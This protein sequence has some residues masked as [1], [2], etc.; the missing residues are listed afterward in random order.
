[1]KRFLLSI[2]L[3]IVEGLTEFLPVSS[4]GHL[5]IVESALQAESARQLLEDVHDRDPA[6]RDPGVAGLFSETNPG[7]SE[8]ISKRRAW[9]SQFSDA[10]AE[11]DDGRVCGH[12]AAGV[13]VDQSDREEPRKPVG[14]QHRVAGRRHCDVDCRCNFYASA[15]DAHGRNEFVPGDL[16]WGARFCRRFFP[17]RRA[18]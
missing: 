16:D 3:G 6:R 2:L 12:G 18:Q 17:E 13:G 9:R 8:H 5:R 4:T 14:D 11:S 7:I 15:R 1:M 10:P